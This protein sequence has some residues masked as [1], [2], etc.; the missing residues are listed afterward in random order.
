MAGR[1]GARGGRLVLGLKWLAPQI[2]TVNVDDV[3]VGQPLKIELVE[4]LE[5]ARD[6]RPELQQ[7]ARPQLVARQDEPLVEVRPDHA[8]RRIA[9]RHP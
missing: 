1:D 6:K 3:Y 9:E 7:L 8:R 2:G 4:A 5:A